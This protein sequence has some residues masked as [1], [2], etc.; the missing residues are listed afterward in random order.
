ME[1]VYLF[2]F[3]LVIMILYAAIAG[4]KD[5]EKMTDQEIEKQLQSEYGILNQFLI[6]PHCQSKGTVRTKTVRRK[7]GVSGA[8]L[9]GAVFT[10]G[11][12]LFVTGFSRKENATQAFCENCESMWDF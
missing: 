10:M 1:I 6:C 8:K 11:A 5:V 2:I 9:T 7:K 3:G 4:P 12:S